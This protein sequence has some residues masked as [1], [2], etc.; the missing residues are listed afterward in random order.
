MTLYQDG[1]ELHELK[2]STLRPTL[3]CYVHVSI[4]LTWLKYW[5]L[6]GCRTWDPLKK[7]LYASITHY[8]TQ[9]CQ[10]LKGSLQPI[11]RG[12]SVKLR[13]LVGDGLPKHIYRSCKCKVIC[14]KR[15]CMLTKESLRKLDSVGVWW[16]KICLPSPLVF[17]PHP[18]AYVSKFDWKTIV[19]QNTVM[20]THQTYVD[21][22]C[23]RAAIVMFAII[24]LRHSQGFWSYLA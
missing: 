18:H 5:M 13:K 17:W 1:N 4:T 23:R 8:H 11:K 14:S 9:I 15:S 20:E 7:F 3:S 24:T 10:V 16:V 6:C 19:S 22:L 21:P 2:M 12:V